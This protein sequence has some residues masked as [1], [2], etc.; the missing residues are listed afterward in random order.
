MNKE[1]ENTSPNQDLDK[2]LFDYLGEDLLASKQVFISLITDNNDLA[3][4]VAIRNRMEPYEKFLLHSQDELP[5]QNRDIIRFN[6]AYHFGRLYVTAPAGTLLQ[7]YQQF[8]RGL[9][10][11]PDEPLDAFDGDG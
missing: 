2:I 9:R 5:L 7:F 6:S 4:E 11:T 8:G 1:G 3:D 10:I